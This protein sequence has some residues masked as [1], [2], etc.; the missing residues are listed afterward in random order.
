LKQLMLTAISIAATPF[1]AWRFAASPVEQNL[2]A[3]NFLPRFDAPD[4]DTLV[5]LQ[6]NA[7]D[8]LR[9]IATQ[10]NDLAL[11]IRRVELFS[12]N[13]VVVVEHSTLETR[14]PMAKAMR[15]FLAN[16]QECGDGLQRFSAAINSGSERCCT[17]IW[18]DENV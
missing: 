10:G 15:A 2:A 6:T 13:L 3:G 9:E 8:E 14:Q 4:L 12:K 1:L 17:R 18:L 7:F 11:D 5:S 16:A